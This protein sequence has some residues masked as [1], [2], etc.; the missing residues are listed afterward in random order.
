MTLVRWNPFREFQD[1]HTRLD[2]L[3]AEFPRRFGDEEPV[4]FGDWAP[5]VDIEETET[6]YSDQG[7]PAGAEEGRRQGGSA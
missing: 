4:L 6:E 7:R 5:A 3:F 1:I 2:R